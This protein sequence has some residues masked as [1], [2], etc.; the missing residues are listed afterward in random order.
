MVM[1]GVPN[2][3]KTAGVTLHLLVFLLALLADATFFSKEE[4]VVVHSMT[5]GGDLASVNPISERV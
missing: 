5:N 4:A 3:P 1:V 2:N